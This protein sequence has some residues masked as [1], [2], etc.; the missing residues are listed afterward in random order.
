[1]INLIAYDKNIKDKRY[2]ERSEVSCC[3]SMRIPIA[4]K[5]GSSSENPNSFCVDL[6]SNINLV[7]LTQMPDNAD[8]LIFLYDLQSYTDTFKISF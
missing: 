2:C 1:M 8:D 4:L 5:K 6:Q 7:H 3:L